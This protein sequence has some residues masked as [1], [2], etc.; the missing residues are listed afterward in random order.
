M[1]LLH[2]G[3]SMRLGLALA[4]AGT[5]LLETSSPASMP[6]QA[7]TGWQ[8]VWGAHR[9]N[10]ITWHSFIVHDF[11]PFC[12][13]TAGLQTAMP[14]TLVELMLLQNELPSTPVLLMIHLCK[15]QAPA[16]RRLLCASAQLRA[17]CAELAHALPGLAAGG[18]AAMQHR[19]LHCTES[20][21]IES[22]PRFQSTG[23]RP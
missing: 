5:A 2:S 16:T 14:R 20:L 6:E 4:G 7:R 12:V 21:C 3:R 9:S 1:K 10:F 13:V 23:N 15:A 17:A 19:V 22:R 11:L 8:W 18:T